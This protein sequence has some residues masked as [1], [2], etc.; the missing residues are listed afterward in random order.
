M[1]NRPPKPAGKVF[2]KNLNLNTKYWLLGGISAVCVGT[3]LAVL[4]EMSYLKHTNEPFIR[5]FLGSIFGFV[6]TI[7]GL[8]LMHEANRFKN[9]IETRK[10]IGREMKKQQKRKEKRPIIPK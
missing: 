6:L 4:L 7:G 10:F 3:G 2:W 9:L 5:W 8:G 1:T